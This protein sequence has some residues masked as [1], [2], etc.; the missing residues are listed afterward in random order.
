MQLCNCPASAALTS[1]PSV[2]CPESFGQIQKVVF[3]RL[4]DGDGNLNGFTTA[5]A[6]TAKA[7]WTELTSANDGKKAVVSPFINAPTDGGGDPITYGS[8]NDV[9]GGMSEIIGSNP[10]TFSAVIRHAPQ[11]VIKVMKELICEARGNN[12]GVYLISENGQIEAIKGAQEGEYHPIPI[13]S[14]FVG[15]KIH[16]NFDQYDS[17]TIQWAYKPNYSDNLEI[18]TPAAGFDPLTDL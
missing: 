18:V 17:N 5:K 16:G 15:D 4:K 10:V 7:S 13:N 9:L 12:L 2:T 11:S 3:Q 1:I 8:G 6:I 14:L